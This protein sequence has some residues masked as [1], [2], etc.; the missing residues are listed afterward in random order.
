VRIQEL[1]DRAKQGDRAAL[2]ELRPLAQKRARAWLALG[3]G[4]ASIQHFEASLGAYATAIELEPALAGDA[5]LLDAV[6][7]A[8]K[9]PSQLAS[10]LDLA[11]RLG[12]T[13][14]DL[15]HA[16]WLE[17]RGDKQRKASA[18]AAKLRLDKPTV[19]ANMSTALRV[20]LDLNEAKGCKAYKKVMPAAAQYADARSLAKLQPLLHTSGC[21]FLGLRD[22]YSCLRNDKDFG[23]ALAR[24]RAESAPAFG[25]AA[26][27][28]PTLGSKSQTQ[29]KKPLSRAGRQ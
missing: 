24:A 10:A 27:L 6:W 19:V 21:G 1:I 28:Q 23:Q 11:E 13:G 9:K 16:L 20:A 4:Y 12:A 15:I 26:E 22:C 2:G 18:E 7:A 3:E 25:A 14:V 29:R 8:A 17:F 5:Q